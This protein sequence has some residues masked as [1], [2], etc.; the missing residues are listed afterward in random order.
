M[1]KNIYSSDLSI[2]Q[3]SVRQICRY[4][5]VFSAATVAFSK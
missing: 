1:H 2:L 5:V 4:Q 3:V